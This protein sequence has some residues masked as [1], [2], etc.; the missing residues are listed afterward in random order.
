[1]AENR[2]DTGPLRYR[3]WVGGLRK[4]ITL[5][6]V[7]EFMERFGEVKEVRIRASVRDTFAFVQFTSQQAIDD[8][9]AGSDYSSG[10]GEKVRA[11]KATVDVSQQKAKERSEGKAAAQEERQENGF[12]QD[13][14]RERGDRGPP[15]DR[16]EDRGYREGPG[17]PPRDE[18]R[19]RDEPRV[20]VEPPRHREEPPP[21]RPGDRR[22][23]PRGRE[24]HVARGRDERPMGRGRDEPMGRSRDEPIGRAREL[25]RPRSSSRPREAYRKYDHYDG[26]PPPRD[27][28]PGWSRPGHREEYY[29]PRRGGWSD[30]RRYDDR[31]PA[32]WDRR[33]RSPP[34]AR[35]P[36][37]DGRRREDYAPR[38]DYPR[39]EEYPRWEEPRGRD[40]DW[41]RADWQDGAY[42]RRQ[43]PDRRQE[44]GW[45]ERNGRHEHNGYRSRSPRRV[46]PPR[47]PE[48]PHVPPPLREEHRA[49]LPR[50]RGDGP[51]AQG[52]EERGPAGKG[53]R[54]PPPPLASNRPLYRVNIENL[55]DD[56]GWVELKDLARD[57]GPSVAFSKTFFVGNVNTGFLDFKDL[58]D[59]EK[60]AQE[61]DNRRVQGSAVRLKATF[62]R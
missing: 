47:R 24:D 14:V 9:I 15:A 61:L 41:R 4:D 31:P 29:E 43:E 51:P 52:W 46:S 3:M 2:D 10:L 30:D 35:Y 19:A 34:R 38:Q 33:N 26:Q 22:E 45:P 37:G 62:Q 18:P 56:M 32:D 58:V 49:G 28:R 12:R 36:E 48:R 44:P 20:R 27:E 16:W 6:E 55:P 1:M 13:R 7:Q 57:F 11:S 21:G 8:A 39:R 59:A 50:P 53:G 23:G 54:H 5:E 17:R 42:P 25:P 40:S 60:V